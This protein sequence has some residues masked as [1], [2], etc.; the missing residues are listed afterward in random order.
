[1]AEPTTT[2][3]VVAATVTGVG[4]AAMLPWLDVNALIG[5]IAGAAVVALHRTDI[6]ALSRILGLVMSAVAGYVCAPELVLQT[7]INQTGPAAVVGA[8]V[9]IPALLRVLTY[10]EKLDVAQWLRNRMGG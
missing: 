10:I 8:V 7:P 3:G 1:M 4:L 6:K 2:A 9:I 5:A